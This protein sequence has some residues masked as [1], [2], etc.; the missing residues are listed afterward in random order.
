M[1]AI[2]SSGAATT[3]RDVRD[4]LDGLA[5]NTVG[6]LVDDLGGCDLPALLRRHDLPADGE[7]AR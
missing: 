6:K 1:R 4:A 2:L 3:V 7:F 5:R